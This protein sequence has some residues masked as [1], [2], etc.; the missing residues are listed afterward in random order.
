MEQVVK[1]IQDLSAK[2]DNNHE[3]VIKEI[4]KN[5]AAI[6][7]MKQDFETKEKDWQEEKQGMIKEIQ[8]LRAR[9]EKQDKRNRI[10][11]IIV[12]GAETTETNA[13]ET[14][15]KL[16]Q[17]DLG[18]RCEIVTATLIKRKDLPIIIVE[19]SSQENKVNVVKIKH[20]LKLKDRRIY[21]D[22]DYTIEE[23]KMQRAIRKRAKK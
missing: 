4:N 7:E 14:V 9:Y 23:R 12:K 8:L 6:E 11:N 15:S 2:M 3:A 10:K 13:K 21:I 18:V 1:L 5:A 22:N 20:K 19:L 16:L 17:N